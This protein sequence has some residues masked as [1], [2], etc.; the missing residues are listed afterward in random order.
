MHAMKTSGTSA[1]A[2][3]DRQARRAADRQLGAWDAELVGG[4]VAHPGLQLLA[5]DALVDQRRDRQ[6][7]EQGS[8][9]GDS[10]LGVVADEGTAADTLGDDV[11]EGVTPAL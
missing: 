1:T 7:V 2:T 6:T 11:L 4:H 10:G 8:H 3:V 9:A 5:V